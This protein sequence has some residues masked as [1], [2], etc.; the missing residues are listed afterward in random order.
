MRDVLSSPAIFAGFPR[1]L[2]LDPE[3]VISSAAHKSPVVQHEK[4]ALTLE[5]DPEIFRYS[6]H[7]GPILSVLQF[8]CA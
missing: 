5:I 7:L 4:G 2:C 8:Y 3:I 1:I 6:S